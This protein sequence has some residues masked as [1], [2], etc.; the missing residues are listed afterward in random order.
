MY[1]L[2]KLNFE[3]DALEPYIDAKT[4]EI[5]YAK[6]HQAYV[7]NLNKAVEMLKSLDMELYEIVSEISKKDELASAEYLVAHIKDVPEKVRLAIRNN[8]G[9]HLNHSLFWE[10]LAPADNKTEFSAEFLEKIAKD[11]GDL[12]EVKETFG[13]MAL[14]N[15]GSGWTWL[16]FDK[17]SGRFEIIN[18]P[19]QDSLLG[20]GIIPVFGI[21]VWEH[22]YYLKYQNRRAEY[23]E[24]F[25]N[26][27][28]FA[29]VE[30]NFQKAL[31]K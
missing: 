25:W 13:L 18:T 29:K 27:L 3:F 24:A 16:G 19:N 7:D 30:A 10:I 21:D 4:M 23:V 1:K 2:P 8:A 17:D 31:N 14:S 6:H 9:G 15:F 26:I 5:H 28:D 22:A 11:Q 20:A 12:N